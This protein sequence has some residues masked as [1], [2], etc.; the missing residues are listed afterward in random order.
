MCV[1]TNF[2]MIILAN[3]FS[4][5]VQVALMTS[6]AI[7][8]WSDM[9]QNPMN[10]WKWLAYGPHGEEWEWLPWG[11]S[12]MRL[13]VTM[14]THPSRQWR[15]MTRISISGWRW[16]PWPRDVLEWVCLPLMA[17]SMLRGDSMMPPL[18]TQWKGVCGR[19]G[20]G[21]G[22]RKCVVP[23]SQEEATVITAKAKS[24]EVYFSSCA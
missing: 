5:N 17:T 18:L 12:S 19:G 8:L 11:G 7:V 16:L 15:S 9:T 6:I 3:S 24:K 22:G 4:S 14:G 1:V 23:H 2:C 21:C 10:G 20:G 13:E